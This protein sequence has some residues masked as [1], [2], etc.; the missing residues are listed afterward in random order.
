M[1][2]LVAAWIAAAAAPCAA[3]ASDEPGASEVDTTHAHHAMPSDVQ[4]PTSAHHP[5]GCPHCGL[6]SS[7]HAPEDAAKHALCASADATV[8]KDAT[9][10]LAKRDLGVGPPA[11]G[12]RAPS[13]PALDLTDG[14]RRNAD[15][16]LPLLP[17]HLRF[18]V[19]LN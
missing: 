19:F 17:R 12:L 4:P 1:P 15:P 13:L 10:K 11:L 14:W 6:L 5:P 2:A 8:A 3:M 9:A 7:D 18:C 16:P